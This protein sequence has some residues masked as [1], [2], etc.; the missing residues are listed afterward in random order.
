LKFDYYSIIK[1]NIFN[2]SS[3]YQLFSQSQ[4]DKLKAIVG[5]EY[6]LKYELKILS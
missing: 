4:V 2:N 6:L 1:E 5:F 3:S